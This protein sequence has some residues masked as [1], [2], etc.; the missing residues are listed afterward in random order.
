MNFEDELRSVLR[1]T[2]PPEGFADRVLRRARPPRSRYR[3]AAWAAA[4]VLVLGAGLEYRRRAE[5]ER[6]RSQ[7]MLALEIAVRQLDSVQLK[8][9]RAAKE[10]P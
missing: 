1:P 4:A 2:P 10:M 9:E 6:A 7:T 5:G 8:L 3:F